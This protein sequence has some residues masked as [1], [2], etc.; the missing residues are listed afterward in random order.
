[1]VKEM[2]SP[3]NSHCG[4]QQYIGLRLP[5]HILVVTKMSPPPLVSYCSLRPGSE[6]LYLTQQLLCCTWLRDIHLND[7]N[8]RIGI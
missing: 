8:L 2:N 4:K 5:L 6:S 1:M 3:R 7:T